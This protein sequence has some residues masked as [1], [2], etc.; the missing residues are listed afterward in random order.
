MIPVS[1]RLEPSNFNTNVRVP[2]ERFL[3]LHG[4]R[5]FTSKSFKGKAY[6]KDCLKDLRDA[7][8]GICAY[9]ASF[10]AL[11]SG[12]SIGTVDHFL[13]KTLVPAL[14]YE[15]S[16]Y[17]FCN[18]KVN[19]NKS[20]LVTIVDPFG[21]KYG[22]FVIDFVTFRVNPADGLPEYLRA[23]VADSISNLGL[24]DDDRIAQPR[25]DRVLEYVRDEV[26]FNHLTKNYPF[27]AF[28]LDRQDLKDQ[29]KVMHS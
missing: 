3:R 10:I 23:R 2:G 18:P 5:P 29:I 28:E 17:R 4:N 13:P 25:A 15:W 24:N 1:E 21:I 22:W 16:N 26:S 8:S 19:E 20:N 14:A 11:D 6:W 27:I 7:Y 12:H 9:T